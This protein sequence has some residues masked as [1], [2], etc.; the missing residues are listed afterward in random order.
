[1]RRIKQ[2]KYKKEICQRFDKYK[3]ERVSHVNTSNNMFESSNTNKDIL[4]E[5]KAINIV[6]LKV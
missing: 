4:S 2:I 5:G 3:K 6:E 1:V